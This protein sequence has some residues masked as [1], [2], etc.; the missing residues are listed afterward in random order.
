MKHIHL[1]A[2]AFVNVQTCI[3]VSINQMGDSNGCF[4]LC[5]LSLL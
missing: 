4:I 1:K 2:T 5:C 3:Y